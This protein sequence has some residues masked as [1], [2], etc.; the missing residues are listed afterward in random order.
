[1]TMASNTT[2]IWR[3]NCSS[4]RS[5]TDCQMG[6]T[7]QQCQSMCTDVCSNVTTAEDLNDCLSSSLFLCCSFSADVCETLYAT[8]IVSSSDTEWSFHMDFSTHSVEWT[9]IQIVDLVTTMADPISAACAETETAEVRVPQVTVTELKW[10]P[11][12]TWRKNVVDLLIPESWSSLSAPLNEV[13]EVVVSLQNPDSNCV[14]KPIAVNLTLT[15]RSSVAFRTRESCK[16]I[17]TCTECREAGCDW[18]SWTSQVSSLLPPWAPDWS[19]VN[20]ARS[21]GGALC[22]VTPHVCYEA[23]GTQN[24]CGVTANMVSNFFLVLIFLVLSFSG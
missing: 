3:L 24:A 6:Q 18:C 8:D 4:G 21:T 20:E 17:V 12:F 1:M 9:S 7:S 2:A 5:L 11:R 14:V 23:F 10:H 19:W 15:S 13:A 22:G 16:T